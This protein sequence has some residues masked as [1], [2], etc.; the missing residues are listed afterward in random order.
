MPLNFEKI[1]T[2]WP[3]DSVIARDLR[4]NFKKFAGDSALSEVEAGTV[5]L[6]VAKAVGADDIIE[7]AQQELKTLGLGDEQIREARESAAIMGMLNS[8][9]KFRSF[10]NK[11]D[12]SLVEQQ[13]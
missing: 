1:E 7:W 12:P 4:L 5:I 11:S 13:Y 6:A 2:R 3:S 10:I 8:Y 9:Y